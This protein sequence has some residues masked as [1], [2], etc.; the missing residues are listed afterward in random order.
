[1]SPI[2]RRNFL[3]TTSA[4]AGA[5]LILT[6]TRAS[7][8]VLGANDRVR[9]AI[10]GLHGRGRSHMG[11]WL[12]QKNV[13]IAYVIDP[14]KNVLAGAM[15]AVQAKTKGKYTT[16]AVTDVRQALEDKNLDA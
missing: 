9:I 4:A 13:E 2:T 10:A 7:G 14:D 3:Q 5:S 1:M 16:Q 15:K 12:G 11:G 6:G 8:N